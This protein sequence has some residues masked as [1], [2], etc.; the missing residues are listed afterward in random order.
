[1]ML[2]WATTLEASNWRTPSHDHQRLQTVADVALR[3]ITRVLLL[4]A[5]GTYIAVTAPETHLSGHVFY[6]YYRR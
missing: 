5:P 1:M 3:S 2:Q 4:I 6:L